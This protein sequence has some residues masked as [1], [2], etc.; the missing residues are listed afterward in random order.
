MGCVLTSLTCNVEAICDNDSISDIPIIIL[1]NKQDIEVCTYECMARYCLVRSD[2]VVG[3]V[4]YRCIGT[5]V[6][7]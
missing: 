3:P 2:R 7:Q 6:A 5:E 4:L 1:A